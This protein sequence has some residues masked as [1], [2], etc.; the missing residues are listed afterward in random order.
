MKKLLLSA[1]L[2]A[3]LGA[4]AVANAASSSTGTITISGSV[5]A[6]TCAVLVNGNA[7][8][9]IT[10]NP[11]INTM[12]PAGASGGWTAVT[13]AV[14]NCAAVAG[15][16]KVYPYFSGAGIDSTN[17]YLLNTAAS[18]S[19][20][21]IA[22]SN[23][24]AITGALTLNGA[25]GSQGAGTMNLSGAGSNGSFTYYAGYVAPTGAG[26]TVGG[27]TSTVQYALNYQ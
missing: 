3:S 19:N 25:S 17:G 8:P 21:E 15:W 6:S 2:V 7:S 13:M 26:A 27:V 10:L 1:V 12:L 20:V 24:Q 22:L 18:G 14:T 11:M 16:S 4:V 5:V 23:T 9:T